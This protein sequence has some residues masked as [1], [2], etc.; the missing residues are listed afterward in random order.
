MIINPKYVQSIS[1]I[2]L[3]QKINTPQEKRDVSFAEI[4]GR[5]NKRAEERMGCRKRNAD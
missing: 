4:L 3:M 5:E 1:N 2:R